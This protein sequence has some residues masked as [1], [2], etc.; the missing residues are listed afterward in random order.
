MQQ[1]HASSA[2]TYPLLIR[3]L[4]HTPM[5]CNADQ[6]IVSGLD[7]RY[8]YRE[9]RAR[10]GLLAAG[11]AAFGVKPG[12]TVAVMD[13]DNHRYLE[14]FFAIPMMAAVLHTINVRLSAEQILFTINHA[15]DDVILLHA[16]FVPIIEQ[17]RDRIETS[18]RFIFLRD[19]AEAARPEFCE[20][21]YEAL[22]QTATVEFEFQDFDE[23]T[24][25]TTFYTTGTT[26]DPKAVFYSHR[27]L[28][29]HTLA[30]VGGLA[31]ADS[32]SRVHR[33][34]VYMPITPMFHVHAWGFPYAATLLGLKQVYPG[35]YDPALLLKLIESEG[36]SFSHCVPTILQMLLSA[37]E[38]GQTDLSGWKVIIGG[39]ALPRGL[40]Q[41]AVQRGIDLFTGYGLSETCPVLT[42]AD[43]DGV[44]EV[45]ARVDVVD[46]C[47]TGKPILMVDLRVVDVEMNDIPRGGSISGEVVVR[48]PWLTQG[49]AGNPEGSEAL[50]EGGYLHTGDV[51]YLDEGGALLI[52][53]RMKDVIKSGG[54]WISSLQLEDI[55]SGCAGVNEVAAFGIAS[56][57]WGERPMLAVVG[58]PQATVESIRA[59][60]EAAIQAAV[61][62]GQISKWAAPERIELLEALPRT[63]VG[64]LDKKRL[65]AQY[66][67]IE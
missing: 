52:T 8:S 48:A 23:N 64:K 56:E 28:V 17:I 22:L 5:S 31:A 41:A 21:E 33:G 51:G 40:A 61:D 20:H 14:C 45:D 10:I 65:R 47:K 4:W 57:R 44:Y 12:D 29:L 55:V 3:Q 35:R 37:P 7:R 66:G 27:Q 9:L 63:S 54:E 36:V 67:Q 60:V 53:D 58:S 30:L 6:E 24:T 50:W 46:R 25:A 32:S 13:W 34:D 42:A 19:T 59:D 38:A 26:G 2:Y 39:A 18:P 43:M 16:D 11:L 15:G 1:T 49:Y 62:A